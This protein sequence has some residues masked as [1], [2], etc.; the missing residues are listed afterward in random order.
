[1]YKKEMIVSN[2]NWIDPKAISHKLKANSLSVKIR[3][4]HPEN[5][6]AIEKSGEKLIVKFKKPQRAVTPGQSAVFYI[7][8]EVIGGG[9]IEN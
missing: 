2:L 8:D 3:Y 4:H 5:P 9:I 1:M 6:C 7:G